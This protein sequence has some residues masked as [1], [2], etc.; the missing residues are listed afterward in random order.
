MV[1]VLIK[2]R[3]LSDEVAAHLERMIREGE[4]AEADRLPSERELMRQFGVGRPSIRE[5]LLHLSKM[6]LVEIKSGERARVTRPTPQF[7]IDALSGPARH[8]ISAPGGVHDFQSARLFF[9]VGL[10]RNAAVHATPEDV[11]SLKEALELNRQSIGDLARFERTDVDFHYVLA[12]IT[13]NRIFTAIHAA[14]AEWLLEQRRTTLAKGEDRKAY[15]AHREI[16]EAVAA[17]D[18]DA[19]EAAMRSHL[20]YVAKRYLQLARPK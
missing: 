17:R 8:M 10:A 11:E 12:V 18:P 1:G 20:E 7:V 6:G 16:F 9:E 15:Q 4:L 14:L 19:S 13:R 2:Q 3:K 5:A